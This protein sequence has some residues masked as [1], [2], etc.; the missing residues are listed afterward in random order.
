MK[1]VSPRMIS[2]NRGDLLSRFG[3]LAAVRRLGT[4]EVAVFCDRDRDVAPLGYRTLR[5]GRLYNFLPSPAGW[6]TLAR[7][8]VVLW[9]G[10]LDL[11]DDSSLLKL[12]HTWCIFL[13]YRLLGL[14]IVVAMQGAGPLTTRAGRWLT[15]RILGLVDRFVARDSGTLRL[16][17]GLG[18]GPRLVRGHD[19][20]FLPD[21]DSA[22]ITPAEEEAVA[23][24]TARAE[25]QKIIGFNLRLWFHFRNSI[26]P[27]HFARAKYQKRAGKEMARLVE[28]AVALVGRLRTE[29][30][31][32]VVLLSMYEPDSQPWEDDLP[33]LRQVKAAFAGDDDVVLVEEPLGLGAVCALVG[34]FDLMIGTRLHSTLTALRLGVP[35][36]NLA[37]TLKC[38]D[39]FGDLGL[40]AN[41]VPLEQF[42]SDPGQVARLA[43]EVLAD[44]DAPRRIRQVVAARIEENVRVLREVLGF[45][46]STESPRG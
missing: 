24:L 29:L 27:Y 6:R 33:Y 10:G 41:A 14:R 2:G 12:L 23:R 11:Q 26:L 42:M 44:E 8:D 19:G 35:A 15:R 39:I 34:Q 43:A 30:G 36:I 9:T 46:G 4:G 37:Y 13:S 25:G 45:N 21:L 32:R 1:I 31:A 20:I 3:I 5:Y 17:E 38:R 7:S 16:L 28:A 40:A 18:A 22:A